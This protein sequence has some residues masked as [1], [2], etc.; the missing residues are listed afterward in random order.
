MYKN[1]FHFN[2]HVLQVCEAVQLIDLSI[3]Q[4]I[5]S[6]SPSKLSY[7]PKIYYRIWIGLLIL[8]V[9]VVVQEYQ[10]VK[11][12]VNIVK[13]RLLSQHLIVYIQCLCLR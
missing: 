12:S 5:S 6:K 10:L 1:R 4:T 7:L 8:L 3:E 13:N 11:K 2:Q 9:L